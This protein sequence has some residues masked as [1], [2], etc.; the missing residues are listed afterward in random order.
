MFNRNLRTALAAVAVVAALP[1]GAAF[2]APAHSTPEASIAF[3][4][5]GGI[6][7]WRAD[8]NQGLW[9]QDTHRHWYYAKLMGPCTGLAFAE[10][11]GFKTEPSGELN[12]W[13][14]IVVRDSGRCYFQSFE[15]SA[16]PKVSR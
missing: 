11:I 14:S 7:D 16:G 6:Y 12:R 13:S 3:A 4:D 9:V 1:V 10:S 2:A 8:G 5:H 15:P